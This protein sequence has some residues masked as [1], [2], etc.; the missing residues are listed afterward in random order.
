MGKDIH[1]QMAAVPGNE[2][3]A[4]VDETDHDVALNFLRPEEGRQKDIPRN[5]I[6]AWNGDNSEHEHPT[7]E[8]RNCE[9]N[10]LQ[11]SLSSN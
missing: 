5:D 7:H 8:A 1:F 6:C 3:G 4:E 10:L 2:D 11:A 9:R